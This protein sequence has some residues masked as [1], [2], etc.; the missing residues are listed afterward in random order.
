MKN[1]QWSKLKSCMML[2]ATASVMYSCSLD[3][4]TD[5]LQEADLQ[6]EQILQNTDLQ[7]ANMRIAPTVSCAKG[8][9]E[10]GSEIY[11]PASD[12]TMESVGPNTK[13]VS[14]SAYNTETDFVVEVTYAISAGPSNAEATIT[15]DIDGS[16][17]EFTEVSSGSTVSHTVP[18]AEDWAGCDEVNFSVVQEGLGTP[19]TF[20]ESYALIPV[21][22][23]IAIGAAYQGGIIAYILQSGDPGYVANETHG[24]IAATSDL[25]PAVWGC[26]HTLIGG[27]STAIGTGAANTAAIIE[28]CLTVGI[29]A[30]LCAGLEL[31]GYDDWYLPSKDELNLMYQN[32]GQGNALGLGNVGGFVSALYWSSSQLNTNYAWLQDF[33]T[34]SQHYTN[35]D[36]TLYYVRAVRAF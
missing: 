35:K 18:L 25:G 4:L 5:D 17:V 23:E 9:I 20:N 3:T 32:I 13:S 26:Y 16:E 7:N 22:P 29:A 1:S 28:G 36:Y 14:Y 33:H 11:Y 31:G 34:G 30:Q 6:N 27:T 21:C 2:L 24:I 10:E 15:I 8:C 19:I 12:M